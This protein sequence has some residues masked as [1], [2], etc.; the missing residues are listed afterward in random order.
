MILL[1]LCSRCQGDMEYTEEGDLRCIQCSRYVY[2]R[3]IADYHH[4]KPTAHAIPL[5]RMTWK[6]EWHS[7]LA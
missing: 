1:K 5:G 3:S 7:D 6:G 4:S 2:S